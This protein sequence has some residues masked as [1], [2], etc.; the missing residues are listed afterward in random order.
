MAIWKT[1]LA[2]LLPAPVGAETRWEWDTHL[3]YQTMGDAPQPDPED[4][5][6]H[7]V[8]ELLAVDE[9]VTVP[10]GTFRAAHVRITAQNR[11]WKGPQVRDLWFGRGAGIVREEKT[12]PGGA[13]KRELVSKDVQDR[14]ARQ[15]YWRLHPATAQAGLSQMRRLALDGKDAEAAAIRQ[16]LAASGVTLP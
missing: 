6:V 14:L 5:R 13:Q 9:A 3:S 15:I 4:T 16:Q 8:G 12:G 7:H 1:A 10:A 11:T 2:R